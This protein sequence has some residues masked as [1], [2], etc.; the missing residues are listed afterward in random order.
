MT[1]HHFHALDSG[2]SLWPV[3][4]THLANINTTASDHLLFTISFCSAPLLKDLCRDVISDF[5]VLVAVVTA[6]T[7]H[8]HVQPNLR[9]CGAWSMSGV[10]GGAVTLTQQQYSTRV[11]SGNQQVVYLRRLRFSWTKWVSGSTAA[12]VSTDNKH[13]GPR[14]R[15]C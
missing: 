8:W 2:F 10:R 7:S 1:L 4:L 3:A 9:H 14:P 6:A 12:S 11:Q 5:S 15:S 13:F